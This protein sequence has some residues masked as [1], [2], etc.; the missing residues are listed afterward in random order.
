MTPLTGTNLFHICHENRNLDHG[1]IEVS[2]AA[3]QA[4]RKMKLN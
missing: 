2:L 4:W 1:R 3:A